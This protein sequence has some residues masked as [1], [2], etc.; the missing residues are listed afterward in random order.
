MGPAT[1]RR[2][3]ARGLLRSFALKGPLAE[4]STEEIVSR[5]INQQTMGE[6]SEAS[7]PRSDDGP[8]PLSAG[9]RVWRYE[10]LDK[11]GEGGMGI[12]YRANDPGLNRRIALKL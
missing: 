9:T 8:Q 7:R 1:R 4:C 6:S 3:R 2:R 5:V 11:V 12:V 10:I